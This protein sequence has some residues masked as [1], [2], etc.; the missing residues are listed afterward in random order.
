MINLF[1]YIISLIAIATILY[2]CTRFI[3]S[4]LKQAGIIKPWRL[5]KKKEEAEKVN[6]EFE[7]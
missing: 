1:K 5:G 3:I 2:F 7:L 4:K 6:D